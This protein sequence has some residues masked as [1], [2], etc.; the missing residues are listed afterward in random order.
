M[1]NIE[2]SNIFDLAARVSIPIALVKPNT[3]EPVQFGSGCI[4]YFDGKFYLLSVAHVTNLDNYDTCIETYEPQEELQSKL[5]SVGGMFY[6]DRYAINNLEKFK[7]EELDIVPIDTLDICFTEIKKHF[8]IHQ[9]E[10][11]YGSFKVLPGE[12]VSLNLKSAIDPTF[13]DQYIFH[14]NINHQ[15]NGIV[16]K[17]E[18]VFKYDLEYK[19]TFGFFHLFNTPNI[20]KNGDDFAGCSGAPILNGEGNIVGLV[21]SVNPGSKMVFAFSIT[22]CIEYLK[23][24]INTNSL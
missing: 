6:F 21:S 10:L 5:Y 12:K 13:D 2:P 14:G 22:R 23:V 24:A 1:W 19:G 4:A 11:D 8:Q 20:I 17:Y 3:L 9:K 15:S 18:P 7:F 16:I